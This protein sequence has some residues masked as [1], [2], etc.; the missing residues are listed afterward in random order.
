MSAFATVINGLNSLTES[1]LRQLYLIVGVR[2]GESGANPA[3]GAKPR[4][5]QPK[6]GATSLPVRAKPVADGKKG[7]KG[8]PSRKSQ[9]ET[10][11]IYREY[12]RLKKVVETQAKESKT[13]F[14]SIQSPEKDSYARALNQ[15]LEA[16][17][18]FRDRNGPKE[19]GAEEPSAPPLAT[20]AGGGLQQAMPVPL[21]GDTIQLATIEEFM[22]QARSSG[23]IPKKEP[24][25]ADEAED[26]SMGGDSGTESET[27]PPAEQ[28]LAPPQKRTASDA[29]NST[30]ATAPKRS[31]HPETGAPVKQQGAPKTKN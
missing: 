6:A 3:P 19:T 5:R 13:P 21:P 15:W 24:T 29:S 8:N 1:E 17:S 22:G 25:W 9:W 4:G 30:R 16:K 12:K 31:G 23:K 2:I 20:V 28:V 11:P 18:S 26:D 7:K 27:E 10:H 14:A